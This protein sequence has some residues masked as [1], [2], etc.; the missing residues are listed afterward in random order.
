MAA[1]SLFGNTNMAAVTSWENALYP[2][3]AE[4]K[5]NED[6]NLSSIEVSMFYNEN[7]LELILKQSLESAFIWSEKL[8]IDLG[9]VVRLA[10]PPPSVPCLILSLTQY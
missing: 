2:E 10:S 7:Y 1:L 6:E 5:T 9:D 3:F 4:E 8:C